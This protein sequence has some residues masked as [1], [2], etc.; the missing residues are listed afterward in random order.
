MLRR[1]THGPVGCGK[2]C[3]KKGI[4]GLKRGRC[5]PRLVRCV[6]ECTSKEKEAK[7]TNATLIQQQPEHFH[8]ITRVAIAEKNE[9]E[10]ARDV[11][12]VLQK[13]PGV[14]PR[15]KTLAEK[16]AMQV[17]GLGVVERI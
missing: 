9:V 7:R 8:L 2:E 1:R 11:I 15:R 5:G 16:N 4:C 6:K 13:H 14:R 10:M 3:D 12:Q 17:S